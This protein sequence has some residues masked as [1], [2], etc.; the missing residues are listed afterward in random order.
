[1]TESILKGIDITGQGESSLTR[2]VILLNSQPNN[3]L[4]T[5]A[6]SASDLR[7]CLVAGSCKPSGFDSLRGN[8]FFQ[9]DIRIGKTIKF[10][11][12]SRLELFFQG[13]DITNHANFGPTYNN[14]IRQ[15]STF[16]TPSG[17]ITPG[18]VVLPH[19]FPG[20]LGAQYRF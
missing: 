10:G 6:M 7:A 1:M 18:S 13:F 11:E 14:N 17:F 20:E 16:G 15:A 4:A 9:W 3:L 19:S 8:P 2:H 12:R 5:A